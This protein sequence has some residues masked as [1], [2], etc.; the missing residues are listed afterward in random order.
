MIF[1]LVSLNSPCMI[2]SLLSNSSAGEVQKKL[3]DR[4]ELQV[5]PLKFFMFVKNLLILESSE[6]MFFTCKNYILDMREN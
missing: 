1:C 4:Y 6:L 5:G 2:L 3:E